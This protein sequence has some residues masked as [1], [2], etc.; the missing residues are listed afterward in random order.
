MNHRTDPSQR[1]GFECAP[2]TNGLHSVANDRQRLHA[3]AR[4]DDIVTMNPRAHGR[5]N[6]HYSGGAVWQL[7]RGARNSLRD[8]FCVFVGP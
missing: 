7:L 2:S 4:I 3:E 8:F 1:S 6:D 5:V